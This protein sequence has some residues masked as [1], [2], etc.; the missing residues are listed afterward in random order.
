[1]VILPRSNLRLEP[2]AGID[3]V[4]KAWVL[5]V[6]CHDQRLLRDVTYQ[7]GVGWEGQLPKVGAKL[8]PGS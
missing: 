4:S 3:V 2:F 7:M 1:M 5:E 8:E 6:R